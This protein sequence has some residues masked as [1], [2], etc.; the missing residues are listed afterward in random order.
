MSHEFITGEAGT[1]KTTLLRERCET[2]GYGVLASTTGISA[3]N[4]GTITINSL[5]KFYN[6]ESLER[7]LKRGKLAQVIDGLVDNEVMG[8]HLCIDEVS[9]MAPR[10]L[11]IIFNAL[12]KHASHVNVVLT[13]D[14]AQLPPVDDSNGFAF[15]AVC[16]PA[17]AAATTR[18][19]TVHRQH[20]MLFLN[21]LRALRRGRPRGAY[22]RANAGATF[23]PQV[24]PNFEG[25]TLTPTNAEADSLNGR[26]LAAL[27]TP[28]KLCNS[29]S[30]GEEA[31]E[32]REIPHTLLLKEGARVIV[33]ANDAP[34][35][36]YANGDTG[37]ITEMPADGLN[38][39]KVMIRLDR[40]GEAVCI[41]P[42]TR[43]WFDYSQWPA[44][45]LGSI[46]YMPIKM[47]WALTIHKSQG[48]T[49][50]KV[51]ITTDHWF[52]GNPALMY[53][54]I[55]RARSAADIRI[56]GSVETLSRRIKSHPGVSQFL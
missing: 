39:R 41:S 49:L 19:M 50:P 33:T 21:A 12:A 22:D 20:D 30:F 35:F 26:K 11:D 27:P 9:M 3:V 32:W 38:V 42:V 29:V 43:R 34:N 31:T 17:F 25:V 52:A 24:D 18:L 2:P 45:M 51:Q 54:A 7:A 44:R 1:G 47:G 4:L 13:G 55:S 8:D 16:W 28:T 15:D 10:Q 48:L 53:V 6:T 46:E 14:F 23:A 5:L 56:V 40:T 36:S 37:V